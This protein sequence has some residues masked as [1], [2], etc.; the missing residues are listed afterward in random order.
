MSR[1]QKRWLLLTSTL[2]LL[3][4]AGWSCSN[5]PVSGATCAE[6]ADCPSPQE[7]RDGYCV[8]PADDDKPTLEWLTPTGETAVNGEITLS[9]EASDPTTSV[10]SVTFRRESE[11][12]QIGIDRD[13]RDGWDT[14]WNTESVEDGEFVISATAVDELGNERTKERTISVNNS[15]PVIEVIAPDENQHIRGDIDPGSQ[16][17]YEVQWCLSSADPSLADN[18]FSLALR[19]SPD[20]SFEPLTNSSGD[21]ASE[22]AYTETGDDCDPST[23]TTKPTQTFVWP[24]P[25]ISAPVTL[26]VSAQSEAGETATGTRNFTIDSDFPQFGEPPLSRSEGED[27]PTSG[28]QVNGELNMVADV[29]DETSQIESVDFIITDDNGNVVLEATDDGSPDDTFS[30]TWPTASASEGVK[31]GTYTIDLTASDAVGNTSSTSAEE[32]QT[33]LT[34]NNDVPD[35]EI[36]SPSADQVVAG[37]PVSVEANV[38][39]TATSIDQTELL[40]NGSSVEV[41]SNAGNSFTWDTTT[42]SNGEVTVTVE[43]E[44]ANGNVGS[45]SKTVVVDNAA[46]NSFQISNY[47]G[48]EYVGGPSVSIS[49]S[50]N[51]THSSVETYELIVDGVV[52]TSTPANQYNGFTW[53]S[54]TVA[55][56]SHQIAVRA[57]DEAGNE[58]QTSTV[59]LN[60]DNTSPNNVAITSHNMGDTVSGS[61]VQLTAQ[62]TDAS[63]VTVTFNVDGLTVGSM[64]GTSGSVQWD[65][66]T[67]MF[68]DGT[69]TIEVIVEDAIGNQSTATVDVEIDNPES[70]TFLT[71]T[72]NGC[73]QANSTVTVEFEVEGFDTDGD[74]QVDLSYPGTSGP[75]KTF[76]PGSWL[77]NSTLTISWNTPGQDANQDPLELQVTGSTNS[78]TDTVSVQIKNNC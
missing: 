19:T 5:N 38:T 55:D 34:V 51:D 48:G 54:T 29:T 67:S 78:T 49:A 57:I 47:S 3:T 73:L 27:I 24:V 62:A 77:P 12:T 64:S 42:S 1:T 35:V 45:N 74:L 9:V 15:L 30:A 70:I 20:G 41:N 10:S 6:T 23:E 52:A 28:T 13:G 26:R 69:A 60:I 58:R 43:A 17:G 33:T 50:T 76:P 16:S 4:A 46:P 65:T 37:S 44:D 68:T 25:E 21:N 66:T 63:D 72:A 75:T 59:E 8:Q 53:D 32:G 7:C 18:P 61:S 40:V 22:L 31:N 11:Q 71:P 14:T 2:C 36:T 39:E 56:G